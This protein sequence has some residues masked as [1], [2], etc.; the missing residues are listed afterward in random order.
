MSAFELNPAHF[1]AIVSAWIRLGSHWT[2]DGRRLRT[3]DA[4][5][6]QRA[7]AALWTANVA[8]VSHRYNEPLPHPGFAPTYKD[9]AA[10]RVD[11]AALLKALDCYE[12]QSGE[13]PAYEGSDVQRA[14]EG[15]RRATI[16]RLAGYDGAAWAL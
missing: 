1:A 6:W 12:Y 4:A 3:D 13:L 5:D 16:R 9:R 8:S 7:M 11:G 10:P 2:L 15:I 14:V